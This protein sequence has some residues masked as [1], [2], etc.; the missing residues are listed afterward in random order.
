MSKFHFIIL[1]SLGIGGLIFAA[2]VGLLVWWDS[3]KRRRHR[4]LKLRLFIWGLGFP[5]FFAISD[6]ASLL[7]SY[8]Y[9]SQK[10]ITVAYLKIIAFGLPVML[11][12]GIFSGFY[13]HFFLKNTMQD[14]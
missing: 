4:S 12:L 3:G 1:A 11:L 2:L 5:L 14:K 9:L 6:I 13:S 8:L 10:H 7:I